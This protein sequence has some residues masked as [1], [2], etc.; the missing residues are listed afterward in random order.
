MLEAVRALSAAQVQIGRWFARTQHMHTTDAAAMVEILNAE[1]RDAPLT[2]AR[3]AERI[4]LTAGATSIL[5]NR[6]EDAGHIT[7]MRGH[8]DRRLVT[9]HSSPEVHRSADAFYKPLARALEN[10]LDDCSPEDLRATERVLN[11]LQ[12]AVTEYLH[13]AE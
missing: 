13:D 6:L 10:A 1:D 4:S 9:L 7:R 8:A 2:P 11:Q 5:L 12:T 3:L